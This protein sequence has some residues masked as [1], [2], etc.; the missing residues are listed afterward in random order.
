MARAL[1]LT[2]IIIIAILVIIAAVLIYL[3]RPLIIAIVI[4][5]AGYFIY[6]WYTKRKLLRSW[7]LV[8]RKRTR[9]S[10]SLL[11][12]YVKLLCSNQASLHRESILSNKKY[13]NFEVSTLYLYKTKMSI[14]GFIQMFFYIDPFLQSRLTFTNSQCSKTLVRTITWYL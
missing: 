12:I 14:Y 13:G 1:N 4:I 2:D 8:D 7:L 6:R 5:T 11:N 9:K 3:L 10:F